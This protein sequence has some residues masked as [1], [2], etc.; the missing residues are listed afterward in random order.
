MLSKPRDPELFSME[1]AISGEGASTLGG[2]ELLE[3]LL[4]LP[5]QRLSPLTRIVS[6]D[7]ES[8]SESDESNDDYNTRDPTDPPLTLLRLSAH[9]EALRSPMHPSSA[10]SGVRQYNKLLRSLPK[11]VPIPE[12][13]TSWRKWIEDDQADNRAVIYVVK[14]ACARDEIIQCLTLTVDSEGTGTTDIQVADVVTRKTNTW[15]GRQLRRRGLLKYSLGV[16]RYGFR[17]LHAHVHAHVHVK[18]AHAYAH[19]HVHVHVTCKTC[20]H[21]TH[22]TCTCACDM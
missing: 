2:T 19:V 3:L 7:S 10:H 1:R 6:L 21:V 11:T 13:E 15:D 22:A 8:G 20:K 9:L 14:A 16:R 18:H 5:E 12:D 4:K 17:G